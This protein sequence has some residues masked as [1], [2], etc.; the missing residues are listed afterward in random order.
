MTDALPDIRDLACSPAAKVPPVGKPGARSAMARRPKPPP[1][2]LLTSTPA[3]RAECLRQTGRIPAGYTYLAQLMGH[4]MGHSL[5]P[6]LVPH[7]P[8][9]LGA[10]PDR[11]QRARYNLI[12]NPLTLE[13]VYGPGPRLLGHL[14]HPDDRTF[15]LSPRVRLARLYP[16][17]PGLDGRPGGRPI[18]ALY[19]ERN[20]DTLMLHELTVAWMQ[21]HNLCARRLLAAGAEPM[22]A[23]GAARAHAVRR[24]H[25]ILRDDL[26]PRLLHPDI[27]G[28][29]AGDLPPAWDLDETTLLHGLFRAFHALPLAAYPMTGTSPQPLGKLMSG[30]AE[31]S[32]AETTGWRIDWP[33]FLGARPG[34][35]A[36]GLSASVAPQLKLTRTIAEMDFATARGA[37]PRRMSAA[38]IRRAV[39][40]LPQPWPGRLTPAA[41]AADFAAAHPDAPH[42]PDPDTIGRGPLYL[43]LLVEAQLHGQAGGFG[44]LGSALLRASFEGSVARVRLAPQAGIAPGLPEPATMNDLVQLVRETHE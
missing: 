19:D 22:A 12:E 1:H 8:A 33:L 43:A 2:I 28:L 13:T 18:R 16:G 5:A 4:D 23:Y 37:G 6:D 21:F 30:G 15:R 20:R 34:G 40:A 11:R 10:S 24:W 27:A 26:L 44:P 9:A 29:P 38:A 41:L 36:T 31:P 39:A 3:W 42:R 35:P 25:A 7:V 17:L 14:Y 32:H